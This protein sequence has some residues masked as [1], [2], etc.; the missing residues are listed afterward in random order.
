[1]KNETLDEDSIINEIDEII[2]QIKPLQE[3]FI[4][5]L[6]HMPAKILINNYNSDNEKSPDTKLT[7][8]INQLGAYIFNLKNKKLR[9]QNIEIDLGKLKEIEDRF[10]KEVTGNDFKFN[11]SKEKY[12]NNNFKIFENYA[13]LRTQLLD[14][15][16]K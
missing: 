4:L 9:N 8:F 12:E 16:E 5:T 10:K 15:C 7:L 3:R 11:Y 14:K 1:M 13:N 2:N 6:E